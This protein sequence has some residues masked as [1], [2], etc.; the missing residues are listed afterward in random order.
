VSLGLR[1][2]GN[3]RTVKVTLAERPATSQ[4][5]VVQG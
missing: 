4:G 1:R 3:E 5:A 2:D